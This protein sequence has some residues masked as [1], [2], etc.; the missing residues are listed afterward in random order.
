MRIADPAPSGYWSTEQLKI[1][2]HSINFAP[3]LT[4]V[5][6]YTGEMVEWLAARGHEVRVVTAPPYYPGWRVGSGYRAGRYVS[7]NW[8]GVRVWRCP[9]WVPASPGGLKRLLHLASFATSSLPVMLGQAAWRADVVWVVE[10]PLFCGPAS[11]MVARLS[12]AQAWL[13]V[14]DF[15]VDAAFELGLLRGGWGRRAAGAWEHWL[16]R[17]FDR[18]STISHRM[19]ERAQ[20][21]GVD[22]D[23]LCLFPNWA[24]EA[25]VASPEGS[26]ALRDELGI[27]HDA[28]VAL[29]S[30]AM[31]RK[32]GLEL[33]A[34]AAF[35]LRGE[36]DLVF[37]FCGNG[38]GR[39]Q[40]M[41]KCEALAGVHFLDLQSPDRLGAL[42][43]MADIH[44]LPQR[45]DAADLV[46]PS[47]LTGMLASGRPVVATCAEGTEI[48]R[49][50]RNHGLITAPG[51][52][53]AFAEGIRMLMH[54]TGLRAH[55]GASARSYALEHLSR[56][57]ILKE[58][59][60]M[61]EGAIH[62]GTSSPSSD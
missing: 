50:V 25:V 15:E 27:A 59:E 28:T 55:L 3:E 58:F 17:R 2:V 30:G 56:D 39:E 7:E 53:K 36:P 57:A 9:I 19:Y 23:R 34:E 1:L 33:M 45:A 60:T 37:V 40:L 14:Q 32:Q 26:E 5:G 29:Y 49:V 48:A 24:N 12:G 51:D 42:L 38:A 44:L 35:L 41:A 62:P 21:K 10:P 8:R 18:V 31:G 43:G 13:H 22:G 4:G 11:W 52:S 54:D 20:A 46:M 6:K 47:K 16:M 61:L